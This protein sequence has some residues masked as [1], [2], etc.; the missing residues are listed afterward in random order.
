MTLD[1]LKHALAASMLV[2][3]GSGSLPS[4]IGRAI[5]ISCPDQ[6]GHIFNAQGVLVGQAT[7]SWKPYVHTLKGPVPPFGRMMVNAHDGFLRISS[8][9]SGS[10]GS[11]FDTYRSDFPDNMMRWEGSDA[12]QLVGQDT[13]VQVTNTSSD[14]QDVTFQTGLASSKDPSEPPIDESCPGAADGMP[15]EDD[16]FGAVATNILVDGGTAKWLKT[17]GGTTTLSIVQ[18]EKGVSDTWREVMAE[19]HTSGANVTIYRYPGLT[20]DR[21]RFPPMV[22]FPGDGSQKQCV[23]VTAHGSAVDVLAISR[24]RDLPVK[25]A[26]SVTYL[27]HVNMPD[28]SRPHRLPK[29]KGGRV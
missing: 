8:S 13:C 24:D 19:V 5:P 28:T 23:L 27:P 6:H 9:G 4:E 22:I 15:I 3:S 25:V 16:E 26:G 2:F 17:Q 11:G 20:G 12:V 21:G 1:K 10:S 7:T 18:A 14:Q 29:R